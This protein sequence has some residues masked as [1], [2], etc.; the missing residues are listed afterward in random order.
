MGNEFKFF[1]GSRQRRVLWNT[2]LVASFLF[3][4]VAAVFT[5][6]ER[7]QAKTII[8][9]FSKNHLVSQIPFQGLTWPGD[10][11]GHNGGSVDLRLPGDVAYKGYATLLGFSRHGNSVNGVFLNLQKGTIDEV[12]AQATRLAKSWKLPAKP[13][14]QWHAKAL[15]YGVRFQDF[16]ISQRH[17]CEPAIGL[18]IHYSFDD[19][20]PV[21]ITIDIMWMN[22]LDPKDRTTTKPS[23]EVP[24]TF[25]TA[26]FEMW[27]SR[28]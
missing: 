14:E 3:L 24:R 28:P 13:L 2:V 15:Q 12:F 16:P 25:D 10:F 20:K 21:F 17:D 26:V 6:R 4:A 5:C 1:G 7:M 11:A 18:E 22:D 8:L 23:A 9:D 27:A 19:W